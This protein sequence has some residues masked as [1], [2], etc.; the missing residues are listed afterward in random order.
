MKFKTETG[1]L[2][3]HQ[4]V[5]LSRLSEKP[6]LDRHTFEPL[7]EEIID[8][9]VVESHYPL[10]PTVGDRVEYIFEDG[11]RIFTSRIVEVLES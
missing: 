1:S 11:R 10:V 2:Y 8:E 6:V 7:I 4:G 5:W 9:R 3:L